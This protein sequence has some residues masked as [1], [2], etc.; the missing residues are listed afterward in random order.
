M[1]TSGCSTFRGCCRQRS[2]CH[3]SRDESTPA[4]A[5]G[6]K[7]PPPPVRPSVESP[8]EYRP[9]AWRYA[10]GAG[11]PRAFRHFAPVPH[12]KS[13]IPDP[14]RLQRIDVWSEASGTLLL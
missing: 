9:A 2:A 7:D 3:G 10:Q 6:P 4:V 12:L 13:K 1:T 5:G 11:G 14:H 8:E